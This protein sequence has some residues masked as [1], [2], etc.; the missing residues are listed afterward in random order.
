MTTKQ[1]LLITDFIKKAYL[2]YFELKLGDHDKKLAS[3]KVC[4]ACP[5]ALR[6]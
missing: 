3:H 2:A 1:R 5:A 4:G 6:K